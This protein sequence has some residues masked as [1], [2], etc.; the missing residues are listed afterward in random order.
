MNASSAT[1]SSP[2]IPACPRCDGQMIISMISPIT[3][4]TDR[5][6]ADDISYL[7]PKC[8]TESDREVPVNR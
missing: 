5:H 4:D 7:C 8:G 2:T 3:D 1:I 6:V